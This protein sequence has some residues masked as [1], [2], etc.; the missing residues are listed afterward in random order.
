MFRSVFQGSL[1]GESYLT[2][3]PQLQFQH[4]QHQQYHFDIVHL[5]QFN[6]AK[7]PARTP[8]TAT[9]IQES[10]D[11]V[12]LD[13]VLKQNFFGFQ[14]PPPF[15]RGRIRQA[16]ATALDAINAAETEQQTVRAW[17][18][19][20]LLPR[21][22][23]H[24]QPGAR[25]L[26]K[27]E[28]YARIQ[29]FQSGQ[30]LVLLQRAQAT[31]ASPANPPQEPQPDHQARRACQLIH[32]GELSAA[33]Q[34][35]TATAL[36]QGNENTLNELRDPN[37]RPPAPY[38]PAGNQTPHGQTLQ[39]RDLQAALLLANLRRARKGAAPGPTGLTSETL[40]LILD[41]E[42][43]TESFI[44]VATKVTQAQLPAAI[45]QAIGLG[46]MV[47][48]QKPNGRVR[49]IVVGDLLRRLVSRCLAQTH[50][51]HI[52]RACSPHQYAL[53]T[54]A[55]AEPLAHSITAATEQNPTN[56]VLSIDGI[57]AYDNISRSSM[58]NA[59]QEVPAAN[60]CLPFV[61]MFYTQPS[62]Y[63]WHDQEGNPHDITQAE[64]GEQGDPLMLALFSLGQKAALQ[65]VQQQLQPGEALYA[66]LDDVYTIV[67]PARVRP[68]FDL[69]S[70][71]L[72]HSAHI[73]LN[74]GKT[75][76]W[77]A[78]GLRPANLEG[79]G[80]NVWVGNQNLPT[81]EEGLMVLGTPLGTPQYQQH[82]LQQLRAQHD[83]LLD[84]IPALG[85]LQASWLLLLFCAAER[86]LAITNFACCAQK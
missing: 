63:V 56:T 34:A 62:T 73:Q 60:R 1:K 33:R 30:W 28:W 82:Q 55:G 79:L 4:R 41:D 35:L 71:H 25:T 54:R 27:P 21:M 81:T 86:R 39:P 83:Q 17:K 76:V 74:T 38:Q 32:Q 77:N 12:D 13:T 43:T 11:Q 46:R 37:R 36:A 61:S 3:Q 67:S 69:L 68:V 57:G 51:S 6:Y 50:A 49:G 2:P 19:W 24:R 16:L 15:L 78:A 23:L 7:G 66:F 84:R 9:A 58:L 72:F 59:L 20:L 29:A 47:A 65:A 22:L 10:L 14:S 85:D 64:G 5:L 26:P 48:L 31:A 44:G 42:Q 40:R 75:R 70:H 80:D 45:S 52:Q 18:L 8:P 53:A